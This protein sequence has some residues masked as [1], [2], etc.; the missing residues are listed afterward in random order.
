MSAELETDGRIARSKRTRESI[1]N[2][3]LELL[4][5]G[6]SQPRAQHIAE[7]AEVSVRTVFQHFDDMEGL[8]SEIVIRQTLRIAPFLIALDETRS[9]HERARSLIELRDNMYALIAPVRNGVRNSEVA[10]HSDLI[11]KGLS[12]LRNA[13][14]KQVRQGFAN[15]IHNHNEPNEVL[16]RIEAVTSYEIWDHFHR[17]QKASRASTRA[18]MLSLLQR[19]LLP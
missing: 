14:N 1:A 2:A 3:L 4:E 19:E 5:E 8:Y 18:H 7:R 6:V 9:A 13:M 17:V 10:R 15:E 16:A 12:D 11:D